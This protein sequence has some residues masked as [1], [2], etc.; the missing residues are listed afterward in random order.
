MDVPKQAVDDAEEAIARREQ[1][2]VEVE[3]AK[4]LVAELKK[5]EEAKKAAL[6][7]LAQEAVDAAPVEK[8][9]RGI[10]EVEAE[11]DDDKEETDELEEGRVIATNS[12]AVN[13]P[14]GTAM[15]TF[16]QAAWGALVF[17]VG[18]GATCVF[19][20][21]L[22]LSVSCLRLLTRSPCPFCEPLQH[23]P[24]SILL[25]ILFPPRAV[26]QVSS[27]LRRLILL[28]LGPFN[29]HLFDR[30]PEYS[31]PLTPLTPLLLNFFRLSLP[32]F[33]VVI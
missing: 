16:K 9:K 2:E 6:V 19:S 8:P 4:R 17:G 10:D 3:E 28:L 18:V 13:P 15:Q 12:R 1:A 27:P 33:S 26:Y 11:Q 31:P 14:P 22:L 32:S 30:S 5:Q 25:L 29:L 24:P 23:D 21:P 7:D 20:T